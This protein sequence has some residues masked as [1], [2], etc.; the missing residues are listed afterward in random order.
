MTSEM[1]VPV[2]VIFVSRNSTVSRSISSVD[3]D[4]PESPSP[5]PGCSKRIVVFSVRSTLLSVPI[6]PRRFSSRR[7]D[8][9]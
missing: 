1:P 9:V 2:L 4:S 8:Y 3:D 6:N 5:E 7:A